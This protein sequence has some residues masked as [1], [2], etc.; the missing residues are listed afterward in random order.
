MNESEVFSQE[1]LNSIFKISPK[2]PD[3]L[4]S[5]ESNWLEFKESFGFGSLNKYIRTAAG[6]ANGTGGYIVYGIG[7]SPHTLL[8]LQGD[9]FN[10]L[11]PEKLTHHLNEQFDP[12]LHWEQHVYEL[13]GKMFGLLYFHESRNK[14]VVCKKSYEDAKALK[15]GE[16]YFRYRGRTQTIRYAELKQLIDE[17]RQMEQLLWFKHL[18]EIARVG[19]ADAAIFD[20]RSGLVKGAHGAF[21]IDESLLPQLAFIK[22]GEFDEVRGRPTLKVIGSVEAVGNA[23]LA[24]KTQVVKT[25]GIRGGDICHAFLKKAKLQDARAYLRQAAYENSAYLPIYFLIRQAKITVEQA[26]E[27]IEREHSTSPAKAKLLERLRGDKRLSNPL[28][29]R[30]SATGMRRLSLRAKIISRE[31]LPEMTGTDLEDFLY[32]LRTLNRGEGNIDRIKVDLLQIFNANFARGDQALNDGI[33][34]S[35]CYL[36]WLEFGPNELAL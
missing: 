16:I 11:D 32:V 36:D 22:E 21:V 6:F 8:G 13:G 3:R 31:A 30:T 26:R 33:R 18:K 1:K 5:R 24:G 15:E 29:S 20:L 27:L 14:P 10:R 19:I 9:S 34:R 17:R 35:L 23:K 25:Q 12:A 2:H 7:R 4:V 28:P